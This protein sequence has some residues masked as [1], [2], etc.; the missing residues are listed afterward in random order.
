[1]LIQMAR[2]KTHAKQ[3]K[4]G[5]SFRPP[6]VFFFPSNIHNDAGWKTKH[7]A[8]ADTQVH[9]TESTR[10]QENHL[11]TFFFSLFLL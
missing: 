3:K 10:F 7:Y 4:K 11:S 1:M 5:S 2:D 6:R 9:Y 8:Q